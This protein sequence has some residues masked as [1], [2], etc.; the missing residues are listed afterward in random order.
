MQA[1]GAQLENQQAFISVIT[2][3]EMLAW[4]GHS[5]ESLTKTTQLV[6]LIPEFGL[7]EP[8]VQETSVSVKPMA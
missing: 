8:I 4:K 5:Q 2:R 7:T 3:I 1:L 6:T